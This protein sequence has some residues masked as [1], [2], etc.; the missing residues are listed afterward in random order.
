MEGEVLV[1]TVI[2]GDNDRRLFVYRADGIP[3]A[4]VKYWVSA[5]TLN[6]G[7]QESENDNRR[8]RLMALLQIFLIHHF[9]IRNVV[10]HG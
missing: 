4:D 8:Q 9:D 10:Y 2:F 5:D 3:I 1:N 7:N 6:V